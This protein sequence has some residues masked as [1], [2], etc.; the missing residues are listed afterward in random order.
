MKARD[1]LGEN[2][3]YEKLGETGIYKLWHTEKPKLFYIGSASGLRGRQS[4]RGFQTRL[5]KH[6]N[7]LKRNRHHSKW[8]Q[9]I[10]NKYGLD[11]IRFEI[12]EIC[13]PENC[14]TKEQEYLDRLKPR[15]NTCKIAGS[16]LG[17]KMPKDKIKSKP[18]LRY[19]LKGEFIDE[20]PSVAEVK[21]VL[22]ISFNEDVINNLE[23]T[24]GGFLWMSKTEKRIPVQ[25]EVPSVIGYNKIRKKVDVYNLDG[26]FYKTFTSI[27]AAAIELGVPSGNISKAL[28]GLNGQAYGYIFKNSTES[29]KNQVEPWIRKHKHQK[30]IQITNLLTGEV[31]VFNSLRSTELA[32]Y[33]R[34]TVS[35][36]LKKETPIF[37]HFKVELLNN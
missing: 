23:K 30:K 35:R 22:K 2:T 20:W 12:V 10:V 33:Y 37:K 15:L 29:P 28:G 1:Y 24:A 17:F 34:R 18:L 36:A 27:K 14:I 9:R 7:A 26:S 19:N 16:T 11:K 4:E 31:N 25:I 5:L 32:G 3:P 13:S 21:R 8:L 6:L